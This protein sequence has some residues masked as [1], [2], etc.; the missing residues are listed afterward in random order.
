MTVGEGM[1]GVRDNLLALPRWVV[2]VAT[3]VPVIGVVAGV[4]LLVM[5]GI[6]AELRT[7]GVQLLVVS[8]PALALLV[9]LLGSTWT[10]TERIDAMVARFLRHTVAAKLEAYLVK[11]A[12]SEGPRHAYPPMFERIEQDFRAEITSYCYYYLYDERG[13]RFDV[14]LKSNIFNFSF[15]VCLRLAE[16]PPGFDTVDADATLNI[17]SLEGWDAISRNPMV[18]MVCLAIHGSL[19][20][21]YTIY[22]SSRRTSDGGVHVSY[23]FRQKPEVNFLTS[24][25]L[26]RYFSEDAAIATY[27]F[28]QEAI[29]NAS[30]DIVDGRL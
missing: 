13:R 2:A 15:K 1:S 7:S 17:D 26:R 12:D 28:F 6:E 25:F 10:R 16:P 23:L 20:E 30:L 5:P 3:S 14:L 24:P 27:F 9:G 4:V 8:V 29:S 18:A 21:G 19:S 22:V 11:P